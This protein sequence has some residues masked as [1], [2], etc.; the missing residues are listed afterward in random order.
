M[1]VCLLYSVCVVRYRSL[2]RADPSSRGVLSTVVCVWVWSSENKNPLQLLW[3]I[4]RRGKEYDTKRNETRCSSKCKWI[5][6][7]QM[8]NVLKKKSIRG[9]KKLTEI[10][11]FKN[12]FPAVSSQL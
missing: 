7:Q 5:L 8:Q 11:N 12:Y 2:R 10:L 4:G 1:D 9:G 3:T 6:V